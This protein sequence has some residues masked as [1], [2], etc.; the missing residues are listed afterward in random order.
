MSDGSSQKSVGEDSTQMYIGNEGNDEKKADDSWTDVSLNDD[1]E[2]KS[3][4]AEE[5]GEWFIL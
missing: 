4:R 5:K 3:N 1:S 2:T